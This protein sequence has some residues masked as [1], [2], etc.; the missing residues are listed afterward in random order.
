MHSWFSKRLN[1]MID[2][3]QYCRYPI[4]QAHFVLTQ[5][6]VDELYGQSLNAGRDSLRT[7]LPLM[8]SQ[9]KLM[10]EEKAQAHLEQALAAL[11]AA[12]QEGQNVVTLPMNKD[13]PPQDKET[14][15]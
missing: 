7:I 6:A 3:S 15:A 11:E 9:A 5:K 14:C 10:G 4:L 2:L 12:R 13:E 8:I 1:E